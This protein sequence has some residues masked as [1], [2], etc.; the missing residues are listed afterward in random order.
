[1]FVV[2]GADVVFGET[3]FASATSPA[4]RLASGGIRTTG[5]ANTNLR[6]STQN[7]FSESMTAVLLSGAFS[8]P[9]NECS[10]RKISVNLHS[11]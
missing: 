7:S 3:I 8:I 2:P 11:R 1:M 6:Y 5:E 10:T 4:F 9:H